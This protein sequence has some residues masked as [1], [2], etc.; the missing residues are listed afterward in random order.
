MHSLYSIKSPQS[1]LNVKVHCWIFINICVILPQLLISCCEL[2]RA[3]IKHESMF[4]FENVLELI[5]FI[6]ICSFSILFNV[7]TII[8]SLLKTVYHRVVLSC[9]SNFNNF[10]WDS[11]CSSMMS[12]RYKYF[13]FQGDKGCMKGDMFFHYK[14]NDILKI[15]CHIICPFFCNFFPVLLCHL[16]FLCW[17]YCF[18]TFSKVQRLR[19]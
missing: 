11:C 18:Y 3:L 17:L 5:G 19:L 9:S 14:S 12:N 16:S 7:D 8:A 10:L 1:T 13:I 15:L 4:F 2:K 6:L